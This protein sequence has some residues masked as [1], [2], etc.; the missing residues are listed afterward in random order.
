MHKPEEYE[1]IKRWHESTG[2][3]SYYWKNLQE[4]AAK[5]NAPLNAIYRAHTGEWETLDKVWNPMTRAKL[6]RL[7]PDAVPEDWKKDYEPPFKIVAKEL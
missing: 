2:S 3:R 7:Y 5:S 1:W 6:A 4:K